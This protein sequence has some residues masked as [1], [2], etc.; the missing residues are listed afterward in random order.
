MINL[1]HLHIV[2]VLHCFRFRYKFFHTT[3][4]NGGC[5]GPHNRHSWWQVRIIVLC[6][7]VLCIKFYWI[8]YYIV[9]EIVL[10]YLLYYI[11]IVFNSVWYRFYMFLVLNSVF[12]EFLYCIY[13]GA[14]LIRALLIRIYS[15]YFQ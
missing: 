9:L 7:I 4:R 15:F 8:V 12:I 6:V 5:V 11:Y 13:S 1:C 3:R 2:W 14:L 10:N